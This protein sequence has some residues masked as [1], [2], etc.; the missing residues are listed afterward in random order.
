MDL[1]VVLVRILF[2]VALRLFVH[3]LL[4]VLLGLISASDEEL[5]VCIFIFVA[6]SFVQPPPPQRSDAQRRAAQRFAVVAA[7]TPVPTNRSWVRLIAVVAFSPCVRHVE[8]PAKPAVLADVATRVGVHVDVV[9]DRGTGQE[10]E[11]AH[12]EAE[13]AHP[14]G[15]G[16]PHLRVRRG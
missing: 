10:A 2:Q 16:D 15:R 11:S 5:R 7:E 12:P 13:S 8:R 14:G 3:L 6:M 1:L 4:C 9:G